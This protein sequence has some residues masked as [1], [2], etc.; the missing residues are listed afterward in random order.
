MA[1]WHE[2]PHTGGQRMWFDHER[3][4]LKPADPP[5]EAK[6]EGPKPKAESKPKPE[7]PETPAD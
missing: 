5:G 3:P 6:S 1:P 7:K 4:D 2:L